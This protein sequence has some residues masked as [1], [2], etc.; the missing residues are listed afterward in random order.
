MLCPDYGQGIEWLIAQ[1]DQYS[2]CYSQDNEGDIPFVVG[3]MDDIQTHMDSKYMDRNGNVYLFLVPEPDQHAQTYLATNFCCFTRGEEKYAYIVYLAPSHSD[4]TQA[5]RFGTLGHP[6]NDYHAWVLMQEYHNAY[7]W[8]T[9]SGAVP[10]WV[11]EGLSTYD[12]LFNTTA[13][14]RTEGFRALVNYVYTNR[15]DAITFSS[16]QITT[17][18]TYFASNLIMKYMADRFGEDV[19][20]YLL[21][22][23]EPTFREAMDVVFDEH[24][25]SAEEEYQSL[26]SWLERCYSVQDC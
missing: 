21:S 19:H 1:E 20:S 17:S 14:N 13:W 24:N 2:V 23:A 6:T 8:L 26:M 10:S 3:L 18:D 25:T 7:R 4:W 5:D 9:V 11:S 12:G 16:G 22:H 15:R